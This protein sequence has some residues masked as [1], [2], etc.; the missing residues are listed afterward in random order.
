ML[1]VED[2]VQI[3]SFLKKSF[4]AESFAVD[5]VHDGETGSYNAR[6][7]DY[8]VII[9]DNML[10]K[11]IGLEV[12]KD[13]R[14]AGKNTPILMLSVKSDIPEKV[15]LF[16]AGVDDYVTKPYSFEEVRARV[17][18]IMR[19]DKSYQPVSL[20]YGKLFMNCD[21]QEVKY[22]EQEI[23]LT[24]KEFSLLE[25]L[26]R[27]AGKVVSRGMIMEHVWNMSA[28]PF[29]RTIETHILNLRKKMDGMAE[30]SFIKN[31]PGRGYKIP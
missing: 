14:N 1:I 16:E 29:S 5:I 28:D 2:E 17:R 23:Y 3:A 11:K 8:D 6:V 12:C 19:R 22:G 30:D 24:R 10:P 7:N 13:I 21:A 27:N 20:T 15:T 26:L 9:L 4:E 25:L 31:I 18:A